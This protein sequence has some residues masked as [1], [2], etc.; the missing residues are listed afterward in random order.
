MNPERVGPE[1]LV[2]EC[3]EAEDLLARCQLSRGGFGGT[4]VTTGQKA[5]E[6]ELGREGSGGMSESSHG[7]Q[8]HGTPYRPSSPASVTPLTL[9]P[10]K[11]S[12]ERRRMPGA[13]HGSPR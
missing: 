1:A 2:A 4:P 13:R 9:C 5:Q 6:Q 12:P 7:Q 10:A 8:D 11:H 3:I